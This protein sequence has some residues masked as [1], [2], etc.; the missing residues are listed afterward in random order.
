MEFETKRV[1]RGLERRV[2]G[3]DDS[4]TGCH[5]EEGGS[6]AVLGGDAISRPADR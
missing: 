6:G 4:V 1:T 2:G 3:E 5:E